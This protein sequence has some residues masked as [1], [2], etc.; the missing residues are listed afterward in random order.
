MKKLLII[1][2]SIFLAG[3]G[4]P[5]T[6]DYS[7]DKVANVLKDK[8]VKHHNDFIT[9]VPV[10]E[11]SGENLEVSFEAVVDFYFSIGVD[12]SLKSKNAKTS[13]VTAE[14]IEYYK[15]W[16]YQSRNK[17]MEKE[18]LNIL[19]KRLKTGKW[20]RLPWQKKEEINTSILPAILE[21]I[22]E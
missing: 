5:R 11:E 4:T 1:P 13:I 19:A 2:L 14:I 6:F 3:C 12:I 9:T 20:E 22:K 8:L 16:S 18:F 15:S 17:K 7:Y 21:D 10:V